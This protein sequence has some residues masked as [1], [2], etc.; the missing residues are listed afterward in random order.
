MFRILEL[1]REVSVRR[2][3]KL[4]I[5]HIT[6]ISLRKL[7]GTWNYGRWHE[8]G[9]WKEWERENF[10][11]KFW[12]ENLKW[13]IRLEELEVNRKI[14]FQWILKRRRLTNRTVLNPLTPNDSYRYRTAP[15]ISKR[16]ILYIYS[17]NTGI[18]HFKHGIYSSFFFSSKCSLFHN[19]NV[20]G[21]CI[22]HILYTGCAKIT[23]II[24][25]P[26]G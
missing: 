18:E 26:K 12:F 6:R 11:Q 9:T 13:R 22:I 10:I 14:I 3:N 1:T 19:S 4:R 7:S 5:K 23:K 17:K 8:R 25:A 20:F 15:L 24:T 16:C 2:L 21:S